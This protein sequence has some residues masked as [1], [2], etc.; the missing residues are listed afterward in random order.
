M[1]ESISREPAVKR[2]KIAIARLLKK[3]IKR[4]LAELSGES[5]GKVRELAESVLG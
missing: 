3:V 2:Q 5:A 1:A 4:G